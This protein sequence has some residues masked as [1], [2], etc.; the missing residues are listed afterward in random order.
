MEKQA[1]SVDE[2]C[3]LN[4]ISRG[5]FYNLLR[6]GA[7]PKIMKVGTRTLVSAEAAAEWRRQMEAPDG[8]AAP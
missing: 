7:G 4:S 3:S 6:D 5:T 1:W 8:G 2:F